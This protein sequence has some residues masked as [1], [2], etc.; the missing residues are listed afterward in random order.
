MT[1]NEIIDLLNAD[2][3][4]T[5]TDLQEMILR[6]AWEKYSYRQM[7]DKLH[8]QEKYLTNL[9]RELWK[10]LSK[11]FGQPIRKANFI[12]ALRER[13]LTDHQAKLIRPR[14]ND[15]KYSLPEPHYDYGPVPLASS[16]Y[17]GREPI[18]D[19]AHAEI[20]KPG[21]VL[22]LR[23]PAK[24]GKTSLLIRVLHAARVHH[25]RTVILN[26]EEILPNDSNDFDR[27]LR[28]FCA[29]IARQL[30]LEPALDRYWNE[31]AGSKISCGL[32]LR[33][34]LLAKEETPLVLA[35]DDVHRLFEYPILS[36]E[37]FSLLRTWHE[38]SRIEPL[39]QRLRLI[40]VHCTEPY[41]PLTLDRSP[42]NVGLTLVLPEFTPAQVQELAGRYGLDWGEEPAIAL[43]RMLGGHPYLIQLTLYRLRWR[44][45]NLDYILESA[46]T[47]N[48]I[49]I[50]HLRS[51]HLLLREHP[52]LAT[53]W[54][55]V[56][57]SSQAVELD[58]IVT[59]RL[60]S[61]GLIRRE[62]N[63]AIPFNNLYRFYFQQQL[64]LGNPN[65]HLESQIARLERENQRLLS[66]SFVDEPTGIGSRTGFDRSLEREWGRS[67]RLETPLALIFCQPD[68]TP[69]ASAGNLPYLQV[70]AR[71]IADSA[72]RAADYIA[73]YEGKRFALLLPETPITG[74]LIVA[75]RLQARLADLALPGPTGVPITFSI[76]IACQIAS[77]EQSPEVLILVT[78]QALESVRST[79]G[80]R[81]AV[82]RA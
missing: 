65:L 40:I 7:A 12:S 42:F 37:F 80:N 57:Q 26:I 49:Y 1:I 10:L 34:Y 79:G 13:S 27:L 82:A 23:S 9:A 11:V 58:A 24:T 63:G 62:T 2:P 33:D 41:I 15:S 20:T 17:I 71:T 22:R 8:Y 51:L 53:A 43:T 76:G 64:S 16:L 46:T 6:L 48:S 77:F 74:A 35:L 4:T 60:E 30:K 3:D 32:Y 72:R 78:E 75:E 36:Q 39:W 69:S 19:L 31:E 52:E 38:E 54:T 44:Q 68:D 28:R 47:A 55:K 66:L 21:A 56:I 73:R 14:S 61:L 67:A 70:I 18:E 25:Y 5:L 45:D 81:I 50:D 29:E 59:R